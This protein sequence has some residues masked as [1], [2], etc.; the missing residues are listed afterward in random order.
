MRAGIRAVGALASAVAVS[1][2][3]AGAAVPTGHDDPARREAE[4][5][6]LALLN[7]AGRDV[8]TSQ[9]SCRFAS[10]RGPLRLVEGGAGAQIRSVL[11]VFRR[12]ATAEERTFAA[13]QA[14]VHTFFGAA[15]LG[16]D[17]VRIVRGADG[18]SVA[19]TAVTDVPPRGPT[20]AVYDRCQRLIRERVTVL[21]PQSR[22]ATVRQARS[23]QR[24]V[25]RSERPPAIGR[26]GEGLITTDLAS[27]GRSTGAGGIA[28]FVA[29]TFAR[30]G[31]GGST[32]IRGLRGSRLTLVVPDGVATIDATFPKRVSRGRYRAPKVYRQTVRRTYTVHDNVVFATAPRPA[33]DAFPKMVWRAADGSIVRRVN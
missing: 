5:R 27:D 19:L 21:A 10:P 11:G 26:A 1:A 23:I 15:E 8:L 17:A 31:T 29:T 9:P 13:R 33:D 22:P 30:T 24:R 3:A 18:R 32:Y 4:A 12:P 25:Q 7:R 28:P 14:K 2:G 6:A 16:R 20:R